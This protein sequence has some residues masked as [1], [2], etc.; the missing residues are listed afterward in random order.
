[1][2]RNKD[3]TGM[4]DSTP[5]VSAPPPQVLQKENSGFSFVVPTEFVELPSQGRFYVEGHP[6]HGQQTIEIRHMT[7]KEEDILTSRT[8]L[9]QGVA[10]ERVINNL[11][12]DSTIDPNSLLVGDRNAILIA[13]RA[14]GYGSLYETAITC[15][16]CTT[17]QPHTFDLTDSEHYSGGDAETTD[18]GDGTYDV[19]LPR[20]NI[21]VTF[22]LLRGTDEKK[23][24][25]LEK[26]NH[27]QTQTKTV[28]TQLKM[29]LVAVEG[30]TSQRTI[31]Y[32]VENLPSVDSRHLR[33][34]YKLTA[35]N[36]DLTQTFVCNE[37]DYS[38][39]MEVPLTADFF[40]PDR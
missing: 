12:V 13:A 1:M 18:N 19:L 38:G 6:L 14:S 16:Q 25:Q 15:P 29:F 31:D 26:K 28:T 5:D 23:L 8:L 36:I 3:R 21:T 22:K 37:C 9:R 11:I 2:S 32:L 10:L 39:D 33:M 4:G 30:D 27:K 34:V 35:P 17:Q 40:W 20:L 7:A 24:F